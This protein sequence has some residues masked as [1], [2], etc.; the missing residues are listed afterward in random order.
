[1]NGRKFPGKVQRAANALDDQTRT[2]RFEVRVMNPDHALLPG[3]YVQVKFIAPKG[4]SMVMIPGDT[5]L[6]PAGGTMVAVVD[7]GKVRM[8]KVD[9]GRDLG[10]QVEVMSGLQGDE[11][12][13]INPSDAVRAGVRVRAVPRK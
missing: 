2:Q 8:Q 6:T 13:I 10:T 4:R 12:L 11:M 7:G 5:L 9:V 1:M 3:M